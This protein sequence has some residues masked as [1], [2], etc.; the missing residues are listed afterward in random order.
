MRIFIR[1]MALT[2]VLVFAIQPS[3]KAEVVS[4]SYWQNLPNALQEQRLKLWY[5]TIAWN[6]AVHQNEVAIAQYYAAAQET[7]K[8]NPTPKVVPQNGDKYDRVANCES[9]M[10]QDA[11]SKDG[12]YLSFF[13]WLLSTWHSAGGTGDPRSHSYE[14]QK[15]RAMS[16]GNPAGQWPVCWAKT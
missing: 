8:T 14:E 12:L 6:E 10:R 3:A 9:S 7:P 5:N 2:L 16:L 15:S 11:V 4:G 13:Q 1:T